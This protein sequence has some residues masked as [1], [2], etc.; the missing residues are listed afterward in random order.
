MDRIKNEKQMGRNDINS[1]D[2]YV[3]SAFENNESLYI[4]GS[5]SWVSLVC[6]LEGDE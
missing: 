3:Y 6:Y 5:V 1:F 2:C 4:L